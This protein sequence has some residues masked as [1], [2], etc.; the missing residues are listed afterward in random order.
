MA[1]QKTIKAV[2]KTRYD[3]AAN[4][5]AKN[6]I[7]AAGEKATESDTHKTKTGDGKTVYN[8]L[9]Y[10]KADTTLTFD[11]TPTAG[12]TNP[13]TSGGVQT[14]LDGKLS[15]SGGTMTGALNLA[16]NTL[17]LAGDDAYF[18]DAN[19]SG[20]LCVKGANNDTGLALVNRNDNKNEDCAIIRYSGKNIVV[21]KSIDGNIKGTAET[22]TKLQTARK[23]NGVAFDGTNDISAPWSQNKAAQTIDLTASTY[24][25]NTWYPV[26][27]SA[28]NMCVLMEYICYTCLGY[29]GTPSWA[30]H[31]AGFTTVIDV[32]VRNSRWGEYIAKSYIKHNTNS[33]CKNNV[34]PAIFTINM[35]Y[36]SGA[37]WY[38]RGG[39]KYCL[40][41]SDTV[42]WRVVTAQTTINGSNSDAQVVAPTTTPPVSNISNL[43]VTS[44]MLKTVATSGSY[45]DLSNKP[46][47]PTKTSQL[48]NDSGYITGSTGVTFE[49]V[50]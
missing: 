45:T 4:F 35:K 15:K 18:G 26:V 10:D 3:T 32:C 24:D 8:N 9:P 46:T 40:F 6:P 44:D 31:R 34:S 49:I 38:L 33:F 41:T 16:N 17:N 36:P 22:A 2:V 12:S 13:V 50:D 39:G 30:T 23:I 21:N 25:Q 42:T 37:V 14:A 7:L 43:L 28:A 47:I 5:K 48:T 29:S 1:T 20:C 11:A 19:K 27:I